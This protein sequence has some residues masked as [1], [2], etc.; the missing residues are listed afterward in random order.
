MN[1]NWFPDYNNVWRFSVLVLK[2]I[3]YLLFKQQNTTRLI[4][5]DWWLVTTARFI[6]VFNITWYTKCFLTKHMRTY[7][8]CIRCDNPKRPKLST[9]SNVIIIHKFLLIIMAISSAIITSLWVLLDY[10][11]FILLFFELKLSFS[12]N[13]LDIQIISCFV[14]EWCNW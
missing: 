1:C 14:I 10:N 9:F 4:V 3:G 6:C 5:A 13:S 7:D 12:L 2:E 11:I 8:V